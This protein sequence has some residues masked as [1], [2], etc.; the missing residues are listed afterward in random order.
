METNAATNQ[1]LQPRFLTAQQVRR[2]EA[3]EDFA[4][5]SD[6]RTTLDRLENMFISAMRDELFDDSAQRQEAAF[7]Y[8]L[9]R[10]LIREFE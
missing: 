9:I 10:D 3:V 8:T 6:T 4:D 5:H 2:L 7:A 1:P